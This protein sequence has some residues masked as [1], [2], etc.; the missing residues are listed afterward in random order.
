MK[1][2]GRPGLDQLLELIAGPDSCVDT[3]TARFIPSTLQADIALAYLDLVLI[4]LCLREG[5]VSKRCQL[6]HLS[7]KG[8]QLDFFVRLR[9]GSRNYGSLVRHSVHRRA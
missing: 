7:S 9:F 5:R 4:V 8:A 2:W 1:E 6:E 3:M